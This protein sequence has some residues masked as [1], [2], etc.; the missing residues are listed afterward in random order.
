MSSYE[1]NSEYI[2]IIQ[3]RFTER[4]GRE[5]GRKGGTER[6]LEKEQYMSKTSMTRFS[7]DRSPKFLHQ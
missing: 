4:G 2:D 5:G 7:R 1:A 6:D 3:H